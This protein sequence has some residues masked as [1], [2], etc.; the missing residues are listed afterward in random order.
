MGCGQSPQPT[1][2][3]R[4]AGKTRSLAMVAAAGAEVLLGFR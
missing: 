4:A 2:V 3:A 1:V